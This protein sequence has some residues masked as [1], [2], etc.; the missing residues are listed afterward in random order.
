MRM[1]FGIDDPIIVLGYVL[2]I[3]FALLC[4]VY[5]WLKRNEGEGSDG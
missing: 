2:S 4:I 3:G 1:I 5:G